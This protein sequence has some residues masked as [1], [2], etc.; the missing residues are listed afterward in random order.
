[1]G[2]F[3]STRLLLRSFFFLQ[4][5]RFRYIVGVIFSSFE[6]VLIFAVPIINEMLVEIATGTEDTYIIRQISILFALF[7]LLV[8]FVTAG[9][10]MLNTANILGT[11]EMRK[12]VLARIQNMPIENVAKY[13][14][15][16]I[17]A[18]ITT[19]V[20]RV[21]NVFQFFII[22]RLA[23]CVIIVA[24]SSVLLIQTDW[25]LGLI[26]F[27]FGFV[28]FTLAFTLNPYVQRLDK[29]ARTDIG[30]ASSLLI[31][32]I[33]GMSIIRVF[34]IDYLISEKY[35]KMVNNVRI[36]RGKFRTMN[37]LSYGVID[38]FIFVV[39][40]IGFAVAINF[41][42][43]GSLTIAQA[44]Y[45]ATLMGVL[46]RGIHSFSEFLLIIQPSIV[47][48]K[49]VFEILDSPEEVI[50]ETKVVPDFNSEIA[51]S[52]K[53]ISFSYEEGGENVLNNI[54]IDIKRGEKLAIVGGTGSGKT[55]LMKLLMGLYEPTKGD[56]VFF[57]ANFHNLSLKD[58]RELSAYVSQDVF[59]LDSTVYD[60]ILLGGKEDTKEDDVIYAAK[61]ANVHDFIIKLPNGYNTI[62]GEKGSSFSGGQRQR[63]SIARALVKN[64]PL[65]LL[66]EATAALDA[67]AE[68]EVV[69]GI[70][71]LLKNT[72][73]IT[74]A[75]KLSTIKNSNRI[76]LLEE[77]QIVAIGTH[78]ELLESSCWYKNSVLSK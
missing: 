38:F 45:S 63:I 26:G 49:R 37:G 27:S 65:L 2:F 10:Y 42:L 6:L 13:K 14:I 7:L 12:A 29:N 1:M 68:E 70:D 71:K 60:N 36:K 61:M 56:I 57:G 72:T 64:A 55:T 24:V 23:Q 33:R 54:T 62:M 25:R 3:K 9:K 74:I 41:V 44:V 34:L 78:D 15:G 76:I 48:V 32:V 77:G 8:P 69:K 67:I 21:S 31:E 16:D 17:I 53:N 35:N 50:R 19:D 4:T 28:S 59:I 20:D 58:I 46:A 66:D 30:S 5:Y 47:S 22:M 51:I 52:L 40:T 43:D 18:S 73:S 39:Q 11:I 75:H